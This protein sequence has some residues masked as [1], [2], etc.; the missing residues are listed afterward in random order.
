MRLVFW[1]PLRSQPALFVCAALMVSACGKPDATQP[2]ESPR[3]VR[4]MVAA[5]QSVS[6]PLTLPGEVRPRI[7]SRLGFR[8]GGKLMARSVSVGDV[9]AP[10]QALARLDPTDLM[11]AVQA[12]QAQLDAVRIERNLA[13][14]ELERLRGLKAQNF[15][16]QSA[17]DRQQSILD[18][19][20]SRLAA[21]EAQL[22]QARNA[23]DFQLL[24]ADVAGVVTAVEAEV[25]QVV[26]AGQTVL[27]IAQTGE[28]EIAINIPEA[29]LA[30][31][32]AIGQWRVTLPALGSRE[33]TGRFREIAPIADP[34]S[35]T[36]PARM[37]LSGPLDGVALGMTASA[38]AMQAPGTAFV[39]PLSALQSRDGQP[40][41]WKV[42]RATSTV[43]PV[44]VKTAGLL[45]DTV[46]ITEGVVAG[47]LIVIA[48]ANLLVAG[49]KV[50]LPDPAQAVR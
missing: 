33:L 24:K 10:G 40:R 2:V 1:R 5:P 21:A 42:D 13:S 15:V 43:Q 14:V 31:A 28:R 11:P 48:G 25:G 46:R 41:V 47:D 32:R 27:R 20:Q 9:V 17:L 22:R 39:L 26:S 34:A 29:D 3:P 49:Q 6:V 19:A 37:T 35:R 7:E 38:Q 45:D 4:T 12:Q 8:V 18:G 36:F 50:R 30:R 16:S 44:A 23:M